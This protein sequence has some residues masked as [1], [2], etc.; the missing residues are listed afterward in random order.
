MILEAEQA[1]AGD[2]SNPSRKEIT[3]FPKIA[4]L[5][6]HDFIRMFLV[7]NIS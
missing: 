4:A 1:Q 7:G 5:Y 3:K 2:S 6:P